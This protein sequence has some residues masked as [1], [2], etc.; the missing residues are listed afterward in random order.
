LLPALAAGLASPSGCDD[1]AAHEEAT[2][3]PDAGGE[4]GAPPEDACPEGGCDDPGDC[5]PHEHAA[6]C[7]LAYAGDP[8]LPVELEL[9]AMGPDDVLVPVEEGGAIPLML[10]PQGGRVIFAGVRARNVDPCSVTITGVLRDPATQKIQIDVRTPNL[11][12][13]GDGWAQSAAGDISTFSNIPTCPNQWSAS[14]LYGQAFDLV[15]T[16]ADVGCKT[17]TKTVRVTPECAE[18]ANVAECLCICGGGYEIG[19]ACSDGEG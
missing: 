18:P 7:T 11:D 17:A 10:P 1:T 19:Q 6:A 14:D 3:P 16:I 9:V 4:G 13:A 5:V 12:L 8:T 2:V 15:M